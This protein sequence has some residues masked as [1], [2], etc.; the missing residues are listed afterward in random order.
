[1]HEL[2]NTG[3]RDQ[4]NSLL[5]EQIVP[6]LVSATQKGEREMRLGMVST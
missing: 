3:A 4:F 1:M 6:T 5:E 2:S